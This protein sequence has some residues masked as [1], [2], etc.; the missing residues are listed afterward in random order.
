[1]A[2]IPEDFYAEIAGC[3]AQWQEWEDLFHLN[4]ED[5]EYSRFL[6]TSNK[7]FNIQVNVLFEELNY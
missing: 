1:M 5:L 7:F 4:E 2:N 6:S 3:E